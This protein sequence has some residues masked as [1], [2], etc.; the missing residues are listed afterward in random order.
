MIRIENRYFN[1]I[2]IIPLSNIAFFLVYVLVKFYALH[3]SFFVALFLILLIDVTN[4]KNCCGHI[5]KNLNLHKYP[6]NYVHP[7]PQERFLQDLPY[8]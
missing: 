5:D 6:S 3:L 4:D 2:E 8:T 1:P 7:L